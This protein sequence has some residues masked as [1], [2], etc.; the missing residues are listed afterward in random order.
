MKSVNGSFVFIKN[1]D[2]IVMVMNMCGRFTFT[3]QLEEVLAYYNIHTTHIPFDHVPRYNVAPGQMIAAVLSHQGENRIGQLKWGL[4]PSW[5]K[6][7]KGSFKMI[8]AKSETILDK[9]A[10]K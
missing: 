7:E 6:D 4:I 8:N 9:P 1:M 5:A 3:T 10:F 2:I